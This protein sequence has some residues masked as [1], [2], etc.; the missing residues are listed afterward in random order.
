MK[1][2]VEM[3]DMEDSRPLRAAT[4][5]SPAALPP[6]LREE[7]AAATRPATPARTDRPAKPSRKPLRVPAG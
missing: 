4:R 6:H 2:T 3:M 5:I 7:G 1:V